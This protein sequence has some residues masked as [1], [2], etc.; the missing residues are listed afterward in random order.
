MP[1]VQ[2]AICRPAVCV[3]PFDVEQLQFLAVLD[4]QT[5]SLIADKVL[6]TMHANLVRSIPLVTFS[7][8]SLFSPQSCLYAPDLFL[9]PKLGPDRRPK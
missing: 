8:D 2:P 1:I 4:R 3:H 7:K 5:S 9:S 6:S